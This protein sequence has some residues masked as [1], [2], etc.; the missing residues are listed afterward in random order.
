MRGGCSLGVAKNALSVPASAAENTGVE[1]WRSGWRGNGGL[2]GAAMVRA[3]CLN[4][5]CKYDYYGSNNMFT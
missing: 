5:T 4:N 1:D 3:S 2:A